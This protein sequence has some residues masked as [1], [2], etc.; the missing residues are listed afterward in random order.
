MRGLYFAQQTGKTWS[1]DIKTGKSMTG[2]GKKKG[3]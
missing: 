3:P 2:K 1:S